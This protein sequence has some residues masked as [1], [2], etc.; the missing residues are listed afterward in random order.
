MSKL[1]RIYRTEKKFI[2]GKVYVKFSCDC[3]FS[4]IEDKKRKIRTVLDKKDGKRTYRTF[5]P[6]HKN[7]SN[8]QHRFKICPICTAHIVVANNTVEGP[9][10]ICTKKIK[11]EEKQKAKV[12]KPKDCLQ[13]G[14][15]YTLRKNEKIISEPMCKNRPYCISFIK[16]AS[17]LLQCDNCPYAKLDIFGD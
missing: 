1:S 16:N 5:C 13:Y 14:L 9:C 15:P 7:N 10:P 6:N 4:D 3:I 11:L 2:P 12:P 8:L 17:T